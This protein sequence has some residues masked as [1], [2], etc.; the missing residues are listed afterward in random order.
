[1]NHQGTK[2]TKKDKIKRL[3]RILKQHAFFAVLGALGVLVVK[4]LVIGLKFIRGHNK[5]KTI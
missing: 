1:L 5:K 4:E 2:F 3:Y